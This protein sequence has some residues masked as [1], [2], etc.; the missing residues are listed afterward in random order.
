ISCAVIPLFSKFKII[1][2]INMILYDH[3]NISNEDMELIISIA[4]EIGTA[5]DKLKNQEELT[6]SEAKNSILLKHIPFS[7]FRISLDG[8]FLDVQLEKKIEKIFEFASSTSNFIGKS[9]YEILPNDIAE[10]AL[11]N[12]E[13]SLETRES[14]EMK[15]R[16]PYKET[17]V[18]FRSDII[19]IGKNEVLAF[20]QNLTRTWELS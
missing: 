12:I 8:I 9:L 13:K 15:F 1:G 19:P 4:L 5:I 20:L 17:Q 18:I 10:E 14:V 6:Q 2:S 11:A 7:I 3:T 16:I